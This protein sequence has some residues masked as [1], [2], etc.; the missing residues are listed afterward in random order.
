[1]S[2]AKVSL[3][4]VVAG[5]RAADLLTDEATERAARVVETMHAVQP[6]FIRAM[7]GFGAWLASLLLIG[8]VVGLSLA[9]DGGYV[10]IG[11]GMVAGAVVLRKRFATDFMVQ[12]TLAASLA[13]QSLLIYGISEFKFSG[14][15]DALLSAIVIM[16][17]VMF[18]IFPDRIHRVLSVM[19]ATTALTILI[20]VHALNAIVPVLGP[21]FAA[22]LIFLY[23]QQ[24][25]LTATGTGALVRPLITGM[26][27]SAFGF[28]LLSTI[29]LLPEL[30]VEY[31]FYPRPWISTLLLG[32]LF[33]YL[34]TDVW[35]VLLEGQKNSAMPVI[36]G[37]TIVVTAAAWEAPGLLLALIVITLGA[38]SGNRV[39]IGAGITFLAVFLAAYFY[40]IQITM[41][42]KSITLVATGTTVLLARWLILKVLART[43][44]EMASAQ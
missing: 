27:L 12:G 4:D 23:K 20:Y 6:W 28:L 42:T 7:V 43:G 16:S 9:I 1:M 39:F 25:K 15:N 18:F 37:L 22:V 32:V 14:N 11:L 26:M 21:V 35:S 13:G 44:G 19:F 24:S 31:A 30:R 17:S 41:L 29:Y 36:Y 3:E 8:F 40:G 38:S 5:L 33:L 10:V 34:V 2:D